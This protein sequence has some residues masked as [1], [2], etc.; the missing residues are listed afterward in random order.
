MNIFSKIFALTFIALSTNL[1]SQDNGLA[2][3]VTDL[4][5]ADVSLDKEKDLPYLEKPFISQSPQDLHDG[6]FVG[7]LGVD[8]GD[9]E[10][11][12]AFVK[13]IIEVDDNDHKTD[14]LLISY[15]GKLVFESY[16][17][18]GRINYPH[19]QM[20]ITKSYTAFT[21][22]RAIQLGHFSMNDLHKPVVHFLKDLDRTKLVAGADTLTLHKIMHMGSGIRVS[23]SKRSQIRH[24]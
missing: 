24:Q 5:A 16:F 12:L 21:L 14:S 17:R 19:Y 10:K 3:E 9:K 6:L 1:A 23:E 18:R 13:E 4:N 22:G 2:S 8:G 11:I 15:K 7:T 20:S